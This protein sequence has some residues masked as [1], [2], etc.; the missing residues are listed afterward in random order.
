MPQLRLALAQVNA[1]LGDLEGNSELVL[2]SCREAAERGAHLVVLP[3]MVLTGYPIEDLAYRASFIAA[4][5]QA[6][7]DLA[8]LLK[9]D[10]LGDLVVV[11][12]H[13][14]R[15]KHIP[16]KLGTPKNAPTNSASVIVGGNDGHGIPIGGPRQ[17]SPAINAGV[18]F[19]GVKATEVDVGAAGIGQEPRTRFHGSLDRRS[20]IRSALRQR[21]ERRVVGSKR[22]ADKKPHSAQRV[23]GWCVVVEA[24]EVGF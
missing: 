15:A 12:G 21:I 14:D 22:L 13:L 24:G 2:A 23:G 5:Q 6:V 17:P 4:S 8:A 16:D 10:G 11:V 18:H 3:E 7:A 9:A 20:Q 1:R 19:V